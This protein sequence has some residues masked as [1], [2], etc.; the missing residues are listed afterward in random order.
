M[1][2]IVQI[3]KRRRR[4]KRRSSIAGSSKLS[5]RDLMEAT[6]WLMRKIQMMASMTTSRCLRT[7]KTNGTALFMEMIILC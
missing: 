2:L 6:T 4:R 3:L 1:K 5:Q 7:Q